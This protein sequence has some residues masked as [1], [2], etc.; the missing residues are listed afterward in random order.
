MNTK[1]YITLTDENFQ[2]EVLENTQPV[3]VDFWADWC[4]PCKLLAVSIEE[5]GNEFTGR[6]KIGK[7][8]I[9]KNN[10]LALQYNIRSIPNLIFFKDGKIVDEVIGVI[11]MKEIAEKLEALIK[12]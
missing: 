1:N 7:V 4:G 2:K 11:P 12:D 5:L 8:D 9:D 6:V 10:S 3:L